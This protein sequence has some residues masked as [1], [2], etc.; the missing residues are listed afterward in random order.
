M[1]INQI[2]V[3][4]LDNGRLIVWDIKQ[5]RELY[6]NHFYGKPLGITKPKYDFEAPLILDP[7]ES[8]YLLEKGY[9]KV[10]DCK[11]KIELELE[12]LIEY[13]RQALDKFEE[14]Y[15]VYKDL[16]D[17]GWIVLPGIKYG[18]DFA[19]YKEGF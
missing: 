1:K 17:K 16:R 12:N 19:V 15:R 9:V 18:C 13:S 14:K 3:D 10:Y 2:N 6:L 4:L 8:V 7:V 5:S 11:E